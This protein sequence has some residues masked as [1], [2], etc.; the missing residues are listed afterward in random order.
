MPPSNHS[1]PPQPGTSHVDYAYSRYGVSSEDSAY[2]G[3]TSSIGSTGPDRLGAH[4]KGHNRWGVPARSTDSDDPN[5][6]SIFLSRQSPRGRDADTSTGVREYVGGRKEHFGR[7]RQAISTPG[8]RLPPPSTSVQPSN[9]RWMPRPSMSDMTYRP[10]HKRA[11]SSYVPRWRPAPTD[12]RLYTPSSRTGT[13]TGT[14]YMPASINDTSSPSGLSGGPRPR[15]A[16]SRQTTSPSS[17]RRAS[18]SAS[19]DWTRGANSTALAWVWD[20]VTETFHRP[21]PRE[22]ISTGGKLDRGSIYL[23]ERK[24]RVPLLPSEAHKFLKH[25]KLVQQ[26]AVPAEEAARK[27]AAELRREVEQMSAED[28]SEPPSSAWSG[29]MPS[30]RTA[31]TVGVLG[32]TALGV[33][34]YM[35]GTS[36]VQMVDESWVSGAGEVASSVISGAGSAVSSLG[37]YLGW[38]A[39]SVA[40]S[41]GASVVASTVAGI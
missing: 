15:P 18:V 41:S 28:I 38:G 30:A 8:S 29:W 16:S 26:S 37:G 11:P 36:P 13:R 31:S 10:S 4:R 19:S 23:R 35:T 22:H 12:P 39:R 1:S 21:A 9:S 6:M 17:N 27:A 14:G 25:T 5:T 3:R 7:S 34:S 20:P 40:G 33:G 24:G 2:T 32:L